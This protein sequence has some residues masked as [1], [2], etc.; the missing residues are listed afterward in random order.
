MPI[1]EHER[2]RQ[3]RENRGD[4]ESTAKFAIRLA[5]AQTSRATGLVAGD[6]SEAL[7]DAVYQAIRDSATAWAFR[8]VLGDA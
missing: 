7:V 1:N 2:Q 3:L 5:I 4:A 6:A 8:E